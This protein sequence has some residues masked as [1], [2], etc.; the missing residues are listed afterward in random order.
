VTPPSRQGTVK[1]I[2]FSLVL[3]GERARTVVIALTGAH[4]VTSA[5]TLTR[6]AA[7]QF[8]QCETLVLDFTPTT[9]VDDAVFEAVIDVI[10]KARSR[11]IHVEIRSRPETYLHDVLELSGILDHHGPRGRK[12]KPSPPV[13]RR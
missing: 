8:E 3:E 5:V 12:H 11:G 6:I 4:G 1:P 13:P 10:G 7:S 9:Q 2:Q